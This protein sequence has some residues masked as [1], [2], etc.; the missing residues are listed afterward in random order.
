MVKNMAH[1]VKIAKIT[2]FY[3]AANFKLIC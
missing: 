2:A 1:F 3:I